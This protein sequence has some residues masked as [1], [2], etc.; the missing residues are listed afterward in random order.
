MGDIQIT[1]L[2]IF[3][4]TLAGTM[5]ISIVSAFIYFIYKGYKQGDNNAG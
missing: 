4:V 2:D 3:Y 1:A 5:V